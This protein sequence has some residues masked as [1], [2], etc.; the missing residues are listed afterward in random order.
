M[1]IEYIGLDLAKSVFQVHG[2][3]GRGKVC[4]S[5]RVQRHAVRNLFSNLP[6]CVVGI[7]ACATAH[8]WGREISKLGHGVRLMPPKYVTPYVKR[9]KNDQV[10]AIG[11]DAPVLQYYAATAGD[12]TLTV[13]GTPF[14]RESY[15]I[16]LPPNS[17]HEEQIN[18]A[19]LEI[20]TSGLGD[21]ILKRWSISEDGK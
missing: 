15:A 12:G 7:E 1:S 4:L 10:D 20:K 11:Y 3:D 13:V 21:E 18:K 5:K 19:L 2:I 8:Y 6:A 16:V 14:K 17:P 9:H